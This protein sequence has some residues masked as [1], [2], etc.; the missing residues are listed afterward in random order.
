VTRPARPR[1]MLCG[2]LG[3]AELCLLCLAQGHTWAEAKAR[4]DAWAAKRARVAKQPRC[5]LGAF[6]RRK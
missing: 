3:P 1:C 6:E 4:A 5:R 2:T